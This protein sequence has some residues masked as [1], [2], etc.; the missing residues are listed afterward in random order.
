MNE[1]AVPWQTKTRTPISHKCCRIWAD[2]GVCH[3]SRLREHRYGRTQLPGSHRA[4]ES[5]SPLYEKR[6]PHSQCLF[7]S[8]IP[9]LSIFKCLCR[10]QGF[11]F[12]WSRSLR[13]ELLSRGIMVT[14]V[15]PYWVRDTGFIARAENEKS[16]GYIWSYP[17][18]SFRRIVARWS[19]NDTWL[20]FAVSTPGIIATAHRIVA[21]FAPE[22]IMLWVWAWVRRL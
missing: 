5:G 3:Y 11:L 21:K 1:S 4:H 2:W 8:S 12:S 20:G 10:K 15:C 22:E 18:A 6:C 9:A 14:A 13:V 19:Y 7:Y 17:L 16:R